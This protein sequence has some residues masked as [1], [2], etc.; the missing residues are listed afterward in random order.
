MNT[1]NEGFPFCAHLRPSAFIC[2]HLRFPRPDLRGPPCLRALRVASARPSQ[3]SPGRRPL[4]PIRKLTSEHSPR[5]RTLM[6]RYRAAILGCGGR[7]RAHAAGY[8]ASPGAEIVGC[9]D[10]VVE[11]ARTLAQ[12]HAGAKAYADYPELLAEQRPGVA[13]ICTWPH[14]HREMVG[15][16]VEAKVAAIHC[17]K[18]MAPTFGD[19]RAMHRAAEKA[20][21]VMTFCHQRRFAPPFRKARDLI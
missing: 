7:G 10:P 19:A 20:G 5:E 4:P 8:A 11:N 17:E 12:A 18:P 1:N 9:A 15:A 13:S 21:V 6:T 16:A 2:V 14:L 3:S